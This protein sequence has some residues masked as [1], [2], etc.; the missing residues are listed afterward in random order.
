[1][2]QDWWIPFYDEGGPYAGTDGR[3]PEEIR[4][5]GDFLREALQLAPGRRVFDQCCGT[6]ALSLPFAREGIPVVGV[7]RSASAIR[8]AQEQSEGAPARYCE[9]DAFTFVAEPACQAAFCW[10][11]AFGNA[12]DDERNLQML[13]RA[14]E[15]L[16]PGGRYALDY[17]NFAAVLAAFQ[18]TMSRRLGELLV[19]R[20][21]ELDLP[22]GLLRQRWT[23]FLPGGESRSG[24]TAVRVYLPDQ[25][26]GLLRA[27]GF[28]PLQFHGGVRG[29]PLDLR[30]LRCVIVAERPGEEK[31]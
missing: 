30:H 11:T 4:Q 2:R 18:P 10:G 1:M 21:S 5:V 23:T 19:V 24:E 6:G 22:A 13:R 26:A 8:C 25:L 27:A 17:P 29:E 31:A 12:A 16:E 3:S 15:S 20:E 28:V 7:D 14:R 9:G